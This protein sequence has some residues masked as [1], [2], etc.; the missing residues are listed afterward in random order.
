MKLELKNVKVHKDMS[1]ETTCFS[2]T[3]YV[4]GVRAADV[5]NDG[6]GG[7]NHYYFSDRKLENE[8][9]EYAKQKVTKFQFEQLDILVGD[10]LEQFE[11]A[12]WL[13]PK[14]KKSTLFQ[15]HG[16]KKGTWR[17]LKAP[18]DA[19]AKTWLVNKYGPQL[20]CI[21]NEDFDKAVELSIPED[22]Y[23]NELETA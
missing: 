11:T 13:K 23:A 16:D 14:L 19:K 7:C 17:I 20:S 3:L 21:A 9:W 22:P 15:L 18:F 12:K 8:V 5:K 2:A 1:E 10:L 6:Q 4:N